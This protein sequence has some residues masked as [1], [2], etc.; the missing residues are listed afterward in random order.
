MTAFVLPEEALSEALN[1]SL[2]NYVVQTMNVKE[3]SKDFY[4]L[5]GETFLHL[6]CQT[7]AFDYMNIISSFVK[8]SGKSVRQVRSEIV[9]NATYLLDYKLF[10]LNCSMEENVTTRRANRLAEAYSVDKQDTNHFLKLFKRCDWFVDALSSRIVDV[11]P[12]FLEKDFIFNEFNEVYPDVIKYVKSLV[13]RKLRFVAESNNMELA[14]LESDLLIKVVQ[15]YYGMVPVREELPLKYTVNYLKRVAH[16]RGMNIIKFATTKRRG[17]LVNV[18][19]DNN[20]VDQFSLL[21]TSMNQT[22]LDSEGNEFSPDVEDER[23]SI[24][25]F[26]VRFSIDELLNKL[27]PGSKKHRFLLILMGMYDEEFTT[28]LRKNRL[29]LQTEDNIDLQERKSVAEFNR[30]LADYFEVKITK[31]KQYLSLLSTKLT[32]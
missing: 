7:H 22:K 4:A 16:N 27:R 3:N 18:G 31:I 10:A 2:S 32:A 17:R 24:A 13:W 15:S 19:K 21:C 23:S 12:H 8:G 30:I 1:P 20:G 11:P 26:E 25:T 28:Y 6:A 5:F 29:C 9:G 14:D